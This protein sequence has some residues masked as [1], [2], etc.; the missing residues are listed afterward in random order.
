MKRQFYQVFS[1]HFSI[2]A[3]YFKSVCITHMQYFV[4]PP[5]NGNWCFFI[6]LLAPALTP[7]WTTAIRR[8]ITLKKELVSNNA[9]N[10]VKKADW[11]CPVTSVLC[12]SAF[13]WPQQP[14]SSTVLTVHCSSKF[15][16]LLVSQL[17]NFDATWEWSCNVD[18][19]S[20]GSSR[21]RGH[22]QVQPKV[23][24]QFEDQK[25][26]RGFMP[27]K[28]RFSVLVLCTTNKPK[29]CQISSA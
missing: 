12:L 11:L 16:I 29:K 3:C 18:K 5:L 22:H 4:L 24:T 6:V 28:F 20:R 13:Q 26:P 25:L 23:Y 10:L 17:L 15:W 27:M 19:K 8:V 9:N 1:S 14:P 7:L 2:T 21:Q